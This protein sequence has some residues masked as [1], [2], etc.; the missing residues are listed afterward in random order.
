MT[1]INLEKREITGKKTRSLRK[2][3]TIPAVIFSADEDSENAQLALHD[4]EKVY[5]LAGHATLVDMTFEGKKFKAIINEVQKSPKNGKFTHVMFNK[6]N[7]K[8]E[9]TAEVPLELIGESEAVKIEKAIIVTPLT[10][11]E[12][13]CLPTDLPAHIQ[14][15]IAALKNIGDSITIG[16][17]TLPAGVKFVHEDDLAQVIASA[18]APQKEEVETETATTEVTEVEL[19]VKKGKEVK[20]EAK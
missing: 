13:K 16:D 4:F 11:V 5:K 19:S 8:E 9:I 20:E 18:A 7:L 14:V 6:V 17:I 3:G 1:H 15:D 12:I 10:S 2:L